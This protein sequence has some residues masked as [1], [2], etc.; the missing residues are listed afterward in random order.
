MW[1]FDELFAIGNILG[2]KNTL[3]GKVENIVVNSKNYKECL[4]EDFG[5]D[6]LDCILAN[7]QLWYVVKL[8]EYGNATTLFNRE[9]DMVKPQPELKTGMFVRVEWYDTGD[10]IKGFKDYYNE[11]GFGIVILEE[12][13]I[14]YQYRASDT[15]DKVL[16]SSLKHGANI[17]EIYKNGIYGFDV[18]NE[19][20]CIWRHPEY[21]K[22]LEL[23][24]N[25]E[26]KEK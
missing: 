22:Y 14:Y 25:L 7:E 17:V 23:K 9:R 26:D 11:Q 10:D 8:D 16:S 2:V 1:N 21:Q 20:N 4:I 3:T 19:N 13:K 6:T 18:C 24:T 12:N 5:I 15:L